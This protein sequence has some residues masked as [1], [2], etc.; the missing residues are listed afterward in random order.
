MCRC[1]DEPVSP[2]SP[3]AAIVVP[4]H[5]HPA[6]LDLSVRSALEQT[7][8]DVEV[9]VVGDGV[10]DD[11]RDVVAALAGEDARVRFLD[12]PKGP[13]HG[14]IHRDR[15]IAATSAG[16]V[17]YLC[18]DDLLLPE[19]IESM[20]ELLEDAD[21]AHGQNGYVD[22]SGAWHPYLADLSSADCRAW[23][24]RPD[25]NAV[26]LTGT[27]HTAAAYRRLPHGWRTTPPGRWPDHYMWQQFLAESWVRA[28]TATRATAVQFPSHVDHRGSWEPAARRAELERWQAMLSTP[29]GL[30]RFEE[31]VRRTVLAKASIESIRRDQLEAALGASETALVAYEEALTGSEASRTEEERRASSLADR[32]SAVESTR[33]WRLR[34]RAKRLALRWGDLRDRL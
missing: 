6:T 14:E 22:A 13:H 2:R 7:V 25:R 21:L 30:A 10:G 19:H 31:G 29:E 3:L 9:V 33:T 18:D 32:L 23:L 28:V 20:A 1:R 15:A 5:D 12:L 34:N 24:L 26:S 8:A 4:T 16:I 17:C 27:A 11:T